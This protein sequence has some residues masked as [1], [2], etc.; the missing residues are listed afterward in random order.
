MITFLYGYAVHPQ[1][2]IVFSK[3]D[4]GTSKSKNTLKEK[5][6]KLKRLN[7]EFEDSGENHVK[8]ENLHGCM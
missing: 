5:G 6:K 7:R 4:A 2:S 3:L 8:K 1:A